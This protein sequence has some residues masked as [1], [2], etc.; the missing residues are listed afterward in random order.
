MTKCKDRLKSANEFAVYL[1]ERFEQYLIALKIVTAQS[2]KN[3]IAPFKYIY[4]FDL[5]HFNY[6]N[7]HLYFYST[8]VLIS[9]DFLA[10]L[11]DLSHSFY[12]FIIC[13]HQSPFA[14]TNLPNT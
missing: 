11:H 1:R 13:F 14:K 8:K 9:L 6:T 7:T 2:K 12:T 4:I 3:K 5:T 10:E